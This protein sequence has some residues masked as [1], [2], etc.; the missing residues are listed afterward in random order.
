MIDIAFDIH[1]D[2]TFCCEEFS[3]VTISEALKSWAEYKQFAEIFIKEHS[4]EKTVVVKAVNDGFSINKFSVALFVSSFNLSAPLEL[5]VFKVDDMEKA[6]EDYKP[7]LALTVALKYVLQLVDQ[8]SKI[9]YKNISILGYLG[10]LIN[11]DYTND[12]MLLEY[13]GDKEGA[14]Y[15]FEA[16]TPFEA[17]LYAAVIKTVAIAKLSIKLK[18]KIYIASSEMSKIDMELLAEQVIKTVSLWIK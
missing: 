1:Q 12:I 17:L 2:N 14:D 7:Y 4:A 6:R 18:I 16:H 15:E 10:V 13:I 8:P 9:I 11:N 5:V 3:I